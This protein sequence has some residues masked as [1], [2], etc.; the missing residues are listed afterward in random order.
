MYRPFFERFEDN[1]PGARDARSVWMIDCEKLDG[2]DQD[3]NLEIHVGRNSRIMKSILGSEDYHAQQT[4]LYV[5]VSQLF[6]AKNVLIMICKNWCHRSVANAESWSTMLTRYGRL[7]HSV[8]TLH[9][10]ELD[11]RKDM[12]TGTRSKCSK[13]SANLYQTH[14]GCVRAECSRL[15]PCPLP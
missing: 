14:H 3:K 10:S 6:S 4:H 12:C 8:S 2:S 15:V 5:G 13:Q 1:Y 7:L 9:P 11:F